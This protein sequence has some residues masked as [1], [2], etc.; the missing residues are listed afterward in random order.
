MLRLVQ[1]CHTEL[2]SFSD[3]LSFAETG[4]QVTGSW[5]P[6]MAAN[7]ASPTPAAAGGSR[8]KWAEVWGSYE[9]IW[10]IFRKGQGKKA[11][12]LQWL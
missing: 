3:G 11:L 2:F 5:C 9:D 7:A 1:S 4:K 6:A 8:W 10:D 12:E